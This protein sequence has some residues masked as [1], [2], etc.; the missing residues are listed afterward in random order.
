MPMDPTLE[1]SPSETPES[2]KEARTNATETP[3]VVASATP[4]TKATEA[5]SGFGAVIKTTS[6]MMPGPTIMVMARGR[7]WR[8][9]GP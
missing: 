5:F 4:R 1:G 3:T 9:I 8:F 7:T 2:S 6:A